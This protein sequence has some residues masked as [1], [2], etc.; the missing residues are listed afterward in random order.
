MRV[1]IQTLEHAL[2]QTQL[3]DRLNNTGLD[4]YE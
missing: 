1:Q 2:M 4:L 3:A